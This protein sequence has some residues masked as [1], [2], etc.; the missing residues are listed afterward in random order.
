MHLDGKHS[1]GETAAQQASLPCRLHRY[2]RV[3]TLLA[4]GLPILQIATQLGMSRAT[5]TAFA[6]ARTFPERAARRGKASKLDAY[7][8]YLQQR[9]A[10]GCCNAS[11]LWRELQTQGYAGTHKQVARWA[12][13]QRTMP[14]AA[15]PKKY[16]FRAH[17]C[18]PIGNSQVPQPLPR[19][20]PLPSASAT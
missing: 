15:A 7:T 14:A 16:G 8:A 19:L 17:H 12:Q 11:Q 3:Q 1:T 13:A 5:I 20:R 4:Q 18:S 9:W 10:A 6:A 2:Q